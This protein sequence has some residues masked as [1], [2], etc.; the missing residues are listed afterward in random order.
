VFTE[1]KCFEILFKCRQCW[2]LPD[3]RWKFIPEPRSSNSECTF[4][5]LESSAWNNEIALWSWL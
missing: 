3:V 5:E 4:A 1:L 2:W